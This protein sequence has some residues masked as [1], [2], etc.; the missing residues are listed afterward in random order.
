MR[1]G[2]TT[3]RGKMS[4]RMAATVLC[5][6]L[7]SFS[8][9]RA[10]TPPAGA[11]GLR[12]VSL[13]PNL[14]EMVFAVGGEAALVGRSSA[15]LYPPDRVRAVPIAGDFGAPSLEALAAL[16]PSAV[17]YVALENKHLADRIESFGIRCERIE[18]RR[19]RDIPDALARVGALVNRAEQGEALADEMRRRFRELESAQFAGPRPTVFVEIWSDPVMTAGKHSFVA[20]L[21]RLAG[22]D[23]IG[24]EVAS[25]DYFRV[26][27]EW[28]LARNPDIILS[29]SQSHRGE[30][31][32][33]ERLIASRTGWD[34]L[35]A[36]RSGRV[37]HSARSDVLTLPGASV[38]EGL[39]EVRG[40]IRAWSESG[41]DAGAAESGKGE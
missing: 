29:L 19:L 3:G 18:C 2:A 21:V 8:C 24:D 40:W 41:S 34:R 20:D 26:S 23:N 14:T 5:A 16:R 1:A 4:S 38:L 12:V 22:G 31:G 11:E 39:E 32:S 15:C 7:A 10:E 37:H 30:P 17:V 36:V 9:R 25:A 27:S 6:G 28:V 33:A 13:A 35:D